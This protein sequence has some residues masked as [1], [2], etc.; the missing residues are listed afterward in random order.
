MF[1]RRNRFQTVRKLN[2]LRDRTTGARET[3]PKLLRRRK[4]FMVAFVSARI[5]GEIVGP[6]QAAAED[7]AQASRRITGRSIP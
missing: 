3:T 6:R 2:D 7:N 5:D 4:G 1:R